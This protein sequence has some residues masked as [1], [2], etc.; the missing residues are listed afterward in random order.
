MPVELNHTIVHV[1]DKQESADFLAGILGVEVSA[2][3]GPFI[4]VPLANHV[5][6]DFMDH[7]DPPA[8]HY[9]FKLTGDE[10]DAAHARLLDQNI[11]TWAD[12]GLS[13]PDQVYEHA[14]EKG[15]YFQ[16]PSGHLMEII[17]DA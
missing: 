16:D 9:A 2:P 5:D 12:P 7:P 15:A 6:L 17:T 13:Q 10:W 14:G 3:F 8:Q 4:P 11:P 1:K